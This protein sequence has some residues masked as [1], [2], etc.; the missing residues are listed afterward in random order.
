[1]V[2]LQE[3]T[4]E[5][6]PAYKAG[7][8]NIC[9]IGKER[10]RKAAEL[11]KQTYPGAKF[12]EGFR[13]LK[14]DSSNMQQVWYTPN[15]YVTKN[16]F[17]STIDNVKLDRTGEDLLFQAMLE[18]DCQLSGKIEISEI[19]GKTVYFVND[20]YIIACFDKDVTDNVIVEIAKKNHISL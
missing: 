17:E 16:L 19:S 15:E 14:L 18:L 13:V 20:N 4:D 8:K 11:I 10:I 7:Y 9:E 3:P 5:K 12:D 6:S 2:Q 1:M